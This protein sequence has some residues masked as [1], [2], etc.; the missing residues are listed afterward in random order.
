MQSLRQQVGQGGIVVVV[1]MG[2]DDVFDIGRVQAER[3]HALCRRIP[4]RVEQRVDHDQ[5]VVGL[6]NVRAHEIKSDV[7]EVVEHLE[8]CCGLSGGL[9]Q[10]GRPGRFLRKRTWNYERREHKH[11]EEHRSGFTLHWVTFLSRRKTRGFYLR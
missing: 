7:I 10:A 5:A 3:L 11:G 9:S 8:R 1:A 6:N 2:D 4:E